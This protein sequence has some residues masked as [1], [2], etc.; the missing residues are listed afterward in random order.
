MKILIIGATRGIGAELLRQALEDG[1][2]V[3]VLARSPRKIALTHPRLHL[4]AGDIRNPLA[5]AAAVK[6]QDAICVTIGSPITFRPVHIFSEG[7]ERVI[8][9]MQELQVRRLICVTGIGAGSSK[10]HGGFLYD[11]IFKPLLLKTIYVDKDLQEEII[12]QSDRDWLIVRPAGLTNGPR[13]RKYRVITDYRGVTARRISR[14]DVAD[15]ILKELSAPQYTG[16]TP[17]LTY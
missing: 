10:G 13:T 9:A 17:L 3:T 4:L 6:G 8:T 16:Q 15:F 1:H 2:E 7:I 11:A 5:V 14:A 12:Q